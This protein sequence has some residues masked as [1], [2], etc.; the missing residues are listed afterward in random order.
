[1][2]QIL[3]S[4]WCDG[5]VCVCMVAYNQNNSENSRVSFSDG[6]CMRYVGLNLKTSW[7]TFQEKLQI[8]GSGSQTGWA[9]K[10]SNVLALF[11]CQLL[12]SLMWEQNTIRPVLASRWFLTA[13][14]EELSIDL[15]ERVLV[16]QATRTLL[17]YMQIWTPL[18]A[19]LI[20]PGISLA[21]ISRSA[22]F[23]V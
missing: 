8:W 14:W 4:G 7:S 2:T 17:Q 13:L 18:L 16:Y 6:L 11:E 22:F 20:K 5:S 19:M 1:M 23:S 9:N 12:L 21:D 15:F 3:W 10:L